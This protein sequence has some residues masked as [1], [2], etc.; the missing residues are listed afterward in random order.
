MLP[1]SRS[2]CVDK[3]HARFDS[4]PPQLPALYRNFQFQL[5][6]NALPTHRRG[7]W[8]RKRADPAAT[9]RSCYI[10]GLGEDSIYHLYDGSCA[11]AVSARTSFAR[12][13]GH[14]LEPETLQATYFMTSMLVHFDP[15]G[16]D[17]A[18]LTAAIVTFNGVLWLQ[19]TYYFTTRPAG[20]LLTTTQ[21]A[22]RISEAATTAWTALI[23]PPPPR[24]FGSAGRRTSAQEAAAVAMVEQQLAAVPSGSIIAF[25]DGSASPNPGPCGAGAVIQFYTAAG[26]LHHQ[27]YIH[28][29]LGLGTNNIGELWAIGMVIEAAH[30]RISEGLHLPHQ[31]HIFSD[32]TYARGCLEEYRSAGVNSHLAELIG[33]LIDNSPIQWS[34]H[35]VPA[36]AGVQLN[37]DADTEANKGTI[38]STRGDGM[39]RNAHLGDATFKFLPS[40]SSFF[41]DFP[42]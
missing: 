28:A 23:K 41:N 10:C 17:G 11:A 33:E 16:A 37:E 5:F 12:A 15:I 6:F 35:W 8:V 24:G 25:T 26:N 19:R 29:G 7:L 4:L 42:T 39:D 14:D 18:R 38:I 13:I 30:H 32:S 27:D 21:A 36:H 2:L 34:I 31:G 40:T 9:T 3:L 20:D 22:S 1:P